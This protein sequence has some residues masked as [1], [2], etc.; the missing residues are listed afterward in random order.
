MYRMLIVDD[1]EIITDG[2]T[3]IFGK[4][5]LELDLY[6]AYSGQEALELLRRTRVDIVLS[7]ICM[8]EMDG[9]ELMKHIHSSWPQC[10]IVFLTGHN[11]FNY[12]YQAIQKPGVQYMLKSE[13][14]PKLIEAVRRAIGELEDAMRMSHLLQQAREQLNTL[15]TLAQGDY[16]R[17]L[18]HSPV[19]GTSL[20]NDFHRLGI[21]LDS[22]LPVLLVH[23]KLDCAHPN[24]SY[25][26]RQDAA[27][28]VKFLAE[29]WLAE[30]TVSTGI[31]DRYGDLI[32]LIQPNAGMVGETERSFN[33]TVTF[34]EGTFEL[35]QQACMTT[36]HVSL[37]VTLSG[38]AGGWEELCVAYDR[39]RRGQH[40]RP[41]DGN[42]MV[43]TVSP[44]EDEAVFNNPEAVYRA[45]R[46]K[47]EMLTIHLEAGR[48]QEFLKLL[49]ELTDAVAGQGTTCRYT[50]ELYYSVALSLLSYANR[51]EL[52]DKSGAAELLHLREP[53][54]WRESFAALR[55]T[56]E[57]LFS[58]RTSG[59]RKRAAVTVEK[60]CAYIDEHIGEDLSLVRLADMIHFNPSYLSRLFKQEQGINLS[61][62]IEQLRL[63]KAKKLLGSDELKVA[64]VGSLVG[65]DSPQSFTRFFK[66]MTRMTPQ[67]YR[68]L[69][70]AGDHGGNKNF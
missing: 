21:T 67:D 47:A 16:F 11:E 19:D 26:D 24:L 46:S 2:L 36:L 66:K 45:S 10:K 34:L 5:D 63:R 39:I 56:A 18:F 61:D 29:S 40:D 53:H 1:E 68:V 60:V 49:D 14:Y 57:T 48:R 30:R 25:A 31:I 28:S 51:W 42:R 35:I 59:E 41:G 3:D 9:L 55:T 37:A 58:V 54:N 65:Y 20:A 7:D 50:T 15:E 44:H 69:A 6:K 27:L 23:G 12:V 13:G 70:E 62:Y 33:R 43:R 38:E 17:H 22:S 32:W 64:E 8:P 52:Q 4:L